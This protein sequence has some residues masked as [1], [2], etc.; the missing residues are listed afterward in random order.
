MH[1]LLSP[2]TRASRTHLHGE[3]RQGLREISEA[4]SEAGWITLLATIGRAQRSLAAWPDPALAG[5]VAQARE[6]VPDGPLIA[7]LGPRADAALEQLA[8]HLEDFAADPAALAGILVE[9]DHLVCAARAHGSP[10][11]LSDAL[12]D[13]SQLIRVFPEQVEPIIPFVRAYVGEMGIGEADSG[14]PLWTAIFDAAG[15]DDTQPSKP[16][17]LNADELGWMPTPDAAEVIELPA[18]WRGPR[19]IPVAASTDDVLPK[20][21]RHVAKEHPTEGWQL[22]FERFGDVRLVLYFHEESPPTDFDVTQSGVVLPTERDAGRFVVALSSAE[23]LTV[24]IGAQ[25]FECRFV[26]E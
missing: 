18:P 23:P 20:P 14:W 2:L 15:F 1:E 9:L 16:T 6:V 12:Q 3:L 17:E 13:A 19:S 11:R 5:A 24:R 7:T 4:E 8:D 26:I 21:S 25:T 22:V 10:D